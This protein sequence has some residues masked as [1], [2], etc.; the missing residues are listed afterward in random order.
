LKLPRGSHLV[1]ASHN[2]GKVREIKA[3]LGPHGIEPI[4]A[5]DLGLPEPDETETT[6]TGNA[7]LKARAA[8]LASGHF[9]LADDS[10]LSVKALDGAPGIY[11]ARWAGPTKDFSLAMARIE[12]ELRE[13]AATDYS[14]WFT[15]ALA[16]CS[17]HGEMQTFVGEVHGTLTFPPQGDHGFGYDPI[18][19]AE[20]MNVTFAQ[21]DP[22]SKH[23]ISH[24]AIAFEKLLHSGVF[25]ESL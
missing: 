15:C 21:M 17:P 8:A 1:V 6:F 23:A 24:R 13:K 20:G 18:F 16:L 5:G 25:I 3:L 10:G 14:A 22:A 19:I 12:R 11:S 2:P 4:G 9:A 7:E